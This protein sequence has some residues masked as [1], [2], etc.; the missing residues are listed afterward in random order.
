MRSTFSLMIAILLLVGTIPA[1][2]QE[3]VL[4]YNSRNDVPEKYQWNIYDIYENDAAWEEA[5]KMLEKMIPEMD[6]YKGKLGES[7]AT[8][9]DALDW[10]YE[11]LELMYE[12]EVYV[13]QMRDVDTRNAKANEM[14]SRYNGLNARISEAVAFVDPEIATIPEKTLKVYMKDE[15]L[16]TYNHLLDNIIR[17]KPHIRSTEVEEALA[18]GGLVQDASREAY[19]AMVYSDI[20]WPQI[21]NAD[22]D[23]ETVSPALYYSFVSN[24][25]RDT[26]RRAA[27]ALF[28]AYTDYANTFAA[29]Y[30]GSVQKDIWL[31]RV[32][33]F[34]TA[35]EAKLFDI[36]VPTKVI[37]TLLSTVHENTDKVARYVDL[38]KKVL[39]IGD[40]HVYDL[41]VGM[42]PEVDDAMTYE[43]A[44]KLALDFW[45]ETFGEEYY[46]IAKQAL[47]EKWVDVYASS[48]KRG[49]AYSWGTYRSHPY[50]LLN[51]GGTL[52][53]AFTLVHEMGH[54]MHT[55]YTNQNQ[56]FHYSDYSL[57]V[58]EVA[59]V[60]AEALF[61]DYM[62]EHETDPGRRLLLLNQRMQN[63][64][65]T[66]LRQIFFHEFEQRA[67]EMAEAGEALTQGSLGELYADLWTSYYGPELV[68]DDEFYAGWSRIPHFY[69]TYYVWVYATSYAA[70][71]AI[72]QRVR[73]GDRGAVQDYLNFLK[74]GNSVYPI[75]ALKVAG[76][77]MTDADVIRNVMNQYEKT[78][79]EM[80]PLLLE[81]MAK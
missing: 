41:Y 4:F 66:F 27:L 62:L 11:M 12:L 2:A 71:E 63:I 18:S 69:R 33:K 72:A 50:L 36:N 39:G 48:G 59:A 37:E 32:H 13:S 15:R 68:L 35:L 56:P 57:F 10:Q 40:F 28:G 58:A 17:S 3:E 29:T 61:I 43:E 6:K 24:K 60:G 42:T 51:W 21:R 70:G 77:D 64:T 5:F 75:D 47:E 8:L 14:Y 38:R 23:L 9:A 54:S 7:A 16:Q 49:G 65:G 67:H 26:R 80:E 81:M 52:E 1:L 45:K 74:L 25:D 55:Y 73:S 76:V 46:T 53:D 30:N 44:T 79:E 34:D 20:Q 19:T 78:L 31:A 22:G